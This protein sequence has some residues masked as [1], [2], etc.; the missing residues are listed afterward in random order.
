M[1]KRLAI[2]SLIAVHTT[3]NAFRLQGTRAFRASAL[4]MIAK[5]GD[6]VPNVIFKCRV[7]DEKI[8]GSN[9][10]KWKDVSSDDLFKGKRSVIFALPGGIVIIIILSD[11]HFTYYF[12]SCYL[13]AFT[14][15]C[16]S[17]HLPGYEEHY[18]AM[19][20]CGIDD[21]YCLSVNDA[22]VMRQWGIHQG[23]EKEDQAESNPL[24]PGNFKKVKLL[25]DGACAFTRGMGMA[26]NWTTE[27]GFGERSWRYSCVINNNKVEKIFIEGGA[28]ITDFGPDPFEVSDAKTMLNYLQSKK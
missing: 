15:T 8:G 3:V 10:F 12:Y 5:E 19:K 28:P 13:L 11:N 17:T 14:P 24:N 4:S 21:I 20:K 27:R 16:S 25:P 1:F 2:F 9:P 26:V 18:E 23:L 7:R 22:F 6:S